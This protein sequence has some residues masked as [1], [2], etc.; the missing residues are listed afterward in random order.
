MCIIGLE[1]LVTFPFHPQNYGLKA[2]VEE[3][4]VYVE[5][6][7]VTNERMQDRIQVSLKSDCAAL[8]LSHCF[9][10]LA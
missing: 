2:D 9:L 5:R 8:Q 6:C 4:R 7:D 1:L 10:H 3:A